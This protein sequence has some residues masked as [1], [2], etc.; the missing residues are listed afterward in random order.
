MA[1][2][3]T[4][5]G[6]LRASDADREDM[7]DTLKTAFVQGRLTKDELDVRAG[8]AFSS[9]TY[10]DLAAITADITADIP[11]GLIEAQSPPKT[12]LA[13]TRKPINKKV[14]A[15]GA[16]VIILPAALGATLFTYYGG[17]F[18]LFLFAF[19]GYTVTAQT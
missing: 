11:A 13:H 5:R 3:A 15:W 14:V 12:A 8:Q 19:I 4:G 10:A 1:A 6:H 17:F 16:C 9:R 2:G 18:V 7:I